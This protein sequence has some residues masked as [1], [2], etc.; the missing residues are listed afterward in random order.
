MALEPSGDLDAALRGKSLRSW[1]EVFAKDLARTW[2]GRHAW[3]LTDLHALN[4]HVER[5]LWSCGMG[6]WPLPEGG[7]WIQTGGQGLVLP[8]GFGPQP[9]TLG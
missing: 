8:E 1:I 9:G 6:V 4:L 5:I 7:T 3:T 2:S